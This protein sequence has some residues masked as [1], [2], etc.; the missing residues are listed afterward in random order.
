VPYGADALKEQQLFK[1]L[2]LP[3][4]LRFYD[5]ILANTAAPLSATGASGGG[6]DEPNTHAQLVARIVEQQDA[7]QVRSV[8]DKLVDQ[9]S[10][11]RIG[12]VEDG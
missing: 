4:D 6:E 10:C 7:M 12:G 8:V 11:A 5:T 2:S 1:Q 9:A 3:Y